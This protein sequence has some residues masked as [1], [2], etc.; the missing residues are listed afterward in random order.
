MNPPSAN[1]ENKPGTRERLLDT[2]EQLF[3]ERGFAATSVRDITDAAGANLGA[4]NY[5]FQSKEN[6]YAGVFQRRGS[7]LRE[8]VLG[9]F[10]KPRALPE[11][12][13]EAALAAFGQAFVTPHTDPV[14]R[15]FLDLCSREA[16]ECQLPPGTFLRE[17]VTPV[18]ETVVRLIR[19]ARPAIEEGTARSCAHSFLAQLFHV[20]RAERIAR[21]KADLPPLDERLAF[22]AHFTAAAVRHI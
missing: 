9:A 2:A 14:Y 3:A 6:L 19:L 13:I 20:A 7:Y 8:L 21:K 5:Y 15:H 12:G 18:I 10:R 4:V 17:F 11:G 22:I 16:T 1:T